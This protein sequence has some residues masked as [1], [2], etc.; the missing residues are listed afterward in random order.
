M[1][2]SAIDLLK[3]IRTV[4]SEAFS[5]F[6]RNKGLTAA[7]SLA[8]LSTL[9]LIRSLTN[10]LKVRSKGPQTTPCNYA[11]MPLCTIFKG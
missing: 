10:I 5:S 4:L 6:R 11:I 2:Q 1:L 7:S 8:F 3:K 9:A